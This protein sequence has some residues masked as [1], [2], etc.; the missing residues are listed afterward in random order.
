MIRRYVVPQSVAEEFFYWVGYLGIEGSVVLDGFPPSSPA[1]ASP[2]LAS[3]E[4]PPSSPCPSVSQLEVSA[5]ASKDTSGHQEPCGPENSSS[6]AISLEEQL[7]QSLRVSVSKRLCPVCDKKVSSAN[8]RKHV[9]THKSKCEVP[10]R[11]CPEC[12]L[13]ISR[14]D[15]MKRHFESRCTR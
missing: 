1:P 15:H 7:D 3:T 8:F 5:S 12:G 6:A 11:T 10:K 4:L 14:N 2:Q 13:E 9:N